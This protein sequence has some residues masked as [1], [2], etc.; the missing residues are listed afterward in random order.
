[1]TEFFKYTTETTINVS[2]RASS[3]EEQVQIRVLT[4]LKGVS[5]A[6]MDLE[7]LKKTNI[8]F[9]ARFLFTKHTSGKENQCEDKEDKNEKGK[10]EE[11][12]MGTG[13]K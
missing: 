9:S 1:M 3:G 6:A 8:I 12:E 7:E 10:E 13:E 5:P 2:K 11:E 4:G